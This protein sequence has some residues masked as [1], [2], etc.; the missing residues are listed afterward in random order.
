MGTEEAA[1][2]QAIEE[3]VSLS[4]FSCRARLAA[5]AL[6]LIDDH[7]PLPRY[8]REVSRRPERFLASAQPVGSG[9]STQKAT[10]SSRFVGAARSWNY[11]VAFQP[12]LSGSPTSM[13][14]RPTRY[15]QGRRMGPDRVASGK[16]R[17]LPGWSRAQFPGS[18]RAGRAS[19]SWRQPDSKR[20]TPGSGSHHSGGR[21]RLELPGPEKKTP[22]V[23]GTGG[24][25][26]VMIRRDQKR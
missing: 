15:A 7:P 26:V 22:P 18:V 23:Q 11:S 24:A 17:G 12:S 9:S 4:L 2:E 1:H 25:E 6:V 21:I 13:T 10:A 3:T 5:A 20:H 19:T 14:Q 8:R 16:E